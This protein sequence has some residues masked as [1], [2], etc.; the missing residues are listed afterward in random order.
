MS[1]SNQPWDE[2]T[3]DYQYQLNKSRV[4]T[5]NFHPN[6]WIKTKVSCDSTQTIETNVLP[7]TSVTAAICWTQTAEFSPPA[8]DNASGR[9]KSF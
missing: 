7:K 1:M 6:I 5:L 8:D 4:E 9:V 2:I 3:N